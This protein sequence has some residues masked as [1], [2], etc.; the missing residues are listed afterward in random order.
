VWL[1]ALADMA[2]ADYLVTGD[3]RSGLLAKRRIGAARIL[4]AAAFCAIIE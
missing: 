4:T 2:R 1:L 3:K